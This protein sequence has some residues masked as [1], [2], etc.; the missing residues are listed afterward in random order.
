MVLVTFGHERAPCV[1]QAEKPEL[2]FWIG[3]HVINMRVACITQSGGDCPANTSMAYPNNAP[4]C[5]FTISSPRGPPLSILS[6]T[7]HRHTLPEDVQLTKR[8]SPFEP[9]CAPLP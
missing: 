7:H 2:D 5:S 4:P 3:H 1:N 9:V 8:S 6:A